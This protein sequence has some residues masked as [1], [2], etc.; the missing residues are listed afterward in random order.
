MSLDK[1]TNDL[2]IDQLNE[3]EMLNEET[4]PEQSESEEGDDSDE[5]TKLRSENKKLVEIIKRRKAHDTEKPKAQSS[6]E[7]QPINNTQGISREEAIL[8]ASGYSE[9]DVNYLNVVAKGTGLS[10]KDA[11]EH[12]LFETYLDKLT[13]E[14]KAKKATLGAS[15][16]SSVTKP[17]S[18]A[19]IS[20]E[21][22]RAIWAEK[23]GQ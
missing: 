5:L 21:E 13:R 17:V 22:H 1:D 6:P 20:K 15:K 12:P 14:K 16:G 8:F 19:G 10:L 7:A 4:E 11:R 18:M 3:E 2:D 23:M 9:D